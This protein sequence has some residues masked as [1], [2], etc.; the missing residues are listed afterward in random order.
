[1]N[2]MAESPAEPEFESVS[3]RDYYDMIMRADQALRNEQSTDVFELQQRL[4]CAGNQPSQAALGGLYLAGRG[5]AKDDL[6]GYA[7]L[8]IAAMSGEPKY[9]KV[10]E[11]L[12]QSMTPEQRTSAD[13]KAA[14]L[15][16]SYSPIP[17]HM[18]CS[19]VKLPRSNMKEL[20][21][22]PEATAARRSF[23]WLKRC[24]AVQ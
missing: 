23:V 7:W 10:A 2:L 18:S 3:R 12:E 1:M 15:K 4:A 20:R 6:T 13:A 8:K 14:K 5:V 11:V 21:C 22:E 24:E 9:K 19:Q 17:A 16:S